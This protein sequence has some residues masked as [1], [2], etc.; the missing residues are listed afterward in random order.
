MVNHTKFS[1]MYKIYHIKQDVPQ[2]LKREYR[3]T[4]EAIKV[5]LHML[6]LMNIEVQTNF[7]LC[8][9][10]RPSL[11]FVKS[12]NVFPNHFDGFLFALKLII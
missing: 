2:R 11:L 3:S 10:Y 9:T 8:I 4:A 7:A 5:S 1:E 12:L 6:I